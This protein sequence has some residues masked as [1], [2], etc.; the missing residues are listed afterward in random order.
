MKTQAL[1]GGRA[2]FTLIELLV[3]ISIIM[4][5]AGLIIGIGWQVVSRSKERVVGQQVEEIVRALNAYSKLE[6]GAAAALQEHCRLGGVVNW[7]PGDE[8]IDIVRSDQKPSFD[9]WR[10]AFNIAA[11]CLK[12]AGPACEYDRY[13]PPPYSDGHTGSRIYY[14]SGA[15]A[16]GEIASADG[17]WALGAWAPLRADL[18]GGHRHLLEAV[19]PSRGPIPRDWYENVWPKWWPLT[20]WDQDDPPTVTYAEDPEAAPDEPLLAT[21]GV[22]HPPVLRF[23]WGDP[24]LRA[25]GTRVDPALPADE[26][27]GQWPPTMKKGSD[28]DPKDDPIWNGWACYGH[29]TYH[30]AGEAN[31][32]VETATWPFLSRSGGSESKVN[33][34][35]WFHKPDDEV[36]EPIRSLWRVDGS[37]MELPYP[38]RD[39]I[40][41]RWRSEYS[42][43][44]PASQDLTVIY[45][46]LEFGVRPQPFDMGLMSPIRTIQLLQA[47]G[48][49]PPGPEGRAAYR[50]DR[51][52]GK[53]WNDPWGGPLVVAYALW[54]PE[55][56]ERDTKGEEANYKVTRQRHL[57]LQACRREYGHSRSLY[58]VVGCPGPKLDDD[59]RSVWSGGAWSA[60]DDAKVLRMLWRQIRRV[61]KAHE[62]DEDL[63]AGEKEDLRK[64]WDPMRKVEENG[65]TCMVSTVMEIH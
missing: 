11:W 55:R 13:Y 33:L 35:G 59:V 24:G 36:A 42:D 34:S 54:L 18:L 31:F 6:R 39:D 49:V 44:T 53:P 1:R 46:D 8:V 10:K 32:P 7:A 17:G 26:E 23:P 20:N 22:Y 61:C 29:Q 30:D 64:E 9:G 12:A 62:W 43:S 4:V 50:S 19:P 45:D 37:G 25:D 5:L 48:I 27:V 21:T 41:Y 60:G 2:G 16:A 47:A 40:V 3:V 65:F 52:P 56:W 51:D 38:S 63:M 28:R 57:L 14:T 58:L 15:A